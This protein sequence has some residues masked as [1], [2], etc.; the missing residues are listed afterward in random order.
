MELGSK[1]LEAPWRWHR[2]P[3]PN[4]ADPQGLE[5]WAQQRIVDIRKAAL[6]VERN[7]LIGEST[8]VFDQLLPYVSANKRVG[9]QQGISSC[10]DVNV[11]NQSCLVCLATFG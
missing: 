4:A 1:Q 5:R 10:Y 2:R 9:V 8:D 7:D 6:A 3:L 11:L